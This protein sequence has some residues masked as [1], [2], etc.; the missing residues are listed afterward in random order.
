MQRLVIVGVVAQNQ[1]FRA[2][3]WERLRA[4]RRSGLYAG[5]KIVV[6][7]PPWHPPSETEYYLTIRT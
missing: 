5:V 6:A 1:K 4:I 7:P 2:R 3:F